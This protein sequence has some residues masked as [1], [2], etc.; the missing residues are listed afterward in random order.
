MTR[1]VLRRLRGRGWL[2]VGLGAS[3]S[4]SV[5]LLASV[6]LYSNGVLQRLLTRDLEQHQMRTG[7]HPGTASLDVNLY[8]LRH[9]GDRAELVGEIQS[10]LQGSLVPALRVPLAAQMHSIAM[11]HLHGDRPPGDPLA[12]Q[13]VAVDVQAFAELPDHVVVTNGRMFGSEARDG[14][15]EAIVTAAAFLDLGLQFG[16]TYHLSDLLG[17]VPRLSVQVV[18]VFDVRDARDLYWFDQ[19]R[20]L[21]AS[22]V[23]DYDLFARDFLA[24]D[25]RN[26][27]RS[28][29]YYAIDYHQLKVT[30]I[31][32]VLARHDDYR[33][34]ATAREIEFEFTIAPLLVSYRERAAVLSR[35]LTFLQI[36]SVLILAFL[37]VMLA[38]L[39]IDMDRSEIASLKSR[40][41]SH[42][43]LVAGYLFEAG[44]LGCVGVVFGLPLAVLI[45]GFIGTSNG[46]LDFVAR[47][48]LPLIAGWPLPLFAVGGAVVFV[49]AMVPPLGRA[50][51]VSIVGA[52]TS[53][54][55]AAPAVPWKR[56][57]PDVL[58]LLLAGYAFLSFRQRQ[59]MDA[60]LP[61][62]TS[63][64]DPVLFLASTAF[65][66]GG[67]LL[68]LRAFPAIVRS[69][70]R[71]GER[72]WPPYVYAG[73][74]QV[75]RSRGHQYF[76]MIFLILTLG[77]GFYNSTTA[78]TIN[79]SGDDELGYRIGADLALQ[80]TFAN[81]IA[82][83]Q[84]GV[85]MGA[86]SPPIQYRAPPIEPYRALPGVAS[87]T[88]VFQTE[89]A[90]AVLADGQR[91]RV[92]VMAIAPTEFADVAWFRR[93]LLPVHWYHYLN[94]LTAAPQAALLSATARDDFGVRRGDRVFLSWHDQL[95]VEVLVYGFV[96]F[97]PGD[98]S[99]FGSPDTVPFVVANFDY[100]FSKMATEPHEIWLDLDG[101][102]SR[103]AVYD[104]ID[105]Q[106]L[107]LVSL[108]D[109]A[110]ERSAARN[111][112]LLQGT[113][114]VLTFG[115]VTAVV[116]SV[117]GYLLYWQFALRQRTLQFGLFRAI[118]MSRR[119]VVGMLMTEQLL[120]TAYAVVGGI[121]IGQLSALVFVPLL[122]LAQPAG[123]LLLPFRVTALASDYARFYVVAGAMLALGAVI[124]R[125]VVRRTRAHEALKL[126]E[127]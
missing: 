31:D 15:Y 103:A 95:P 84:Q 60:L 126:G 38:Q 121:A 17:D 94:L 76:V 37:I 1:L 29:W 109:L 7:R 53:L 105:A 115:F 48:P 118:G 33:R 46:F 35:T 81:D 88:R 72:S 27:A 25:T 13:R 73:L 63:P 92:R 59:Q 55:R 4:L 93:D 42:R 41:A 6:P 78:R 70:V 65:V 66:L 82:I 99:A 87:A 83:E 47:P 77:M 28:R 80:P 26:L 18:G 98:R 68:I 11:D 24:T 16:R 104:A 79:K 20:T 12:G 97:W 96:D 120:A 113:N 124:F 22:F 85:E 117:I 19:F 100:L 119:Q 102:A 74:L 107:S 86:A 62:G 39:V 57:F 9:R 69:L 114:G 71:V 36:P 110:Q 8:Q 3:A 10:M 2:A 91:E 89:R 21:D 108:R 34:L 45:V 44:F 112:P 56:L 61:T 50:V 58:L 54:S 122:E 106:R 67:G 40:G 111:D 64:I 30:D 127:E 5:A 23:I 116:V 32:N 75:G 123:H 51:R 43:E 14:V 90:R 52:K 125:S 101:D 49:A